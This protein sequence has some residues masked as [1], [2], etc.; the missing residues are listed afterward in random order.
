MIVHICEQWAWEEAQD[1]NEYRTESLDTVGFIHCSRPEQVL[2]VA[3]RYYQDVPD[4]LLLWIDPDK[5]RSEIRWELSEDETYPH[6]YG[7]LN[8]DAV[9]IVTGLVPDENGE[10]TRLRLRPWTGNHPIK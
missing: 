3:S 6:I 10:F 4:L 1:N 9:T 7:P 2:G 8:I 5:V